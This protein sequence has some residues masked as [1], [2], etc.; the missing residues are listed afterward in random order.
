MD[1][2]MSQTIIRY[3]SEVDGIYFF[4]ERS[5]RWRRF[6]GRLDSLRLFF[7]TELRTRK[8][9]AVTS[10][11]KK[12][13]RIT[14]NDLHIST[15]HHKPVYLCASIFFAP[16]RPLSRSNDDDVS[17]LRISYGMRMLLAQVA[18]AVA[19]SFAVSVQVAQEVL[20][21]RFCI[22]FQLRHMPLS[23]SKPAS[24]N[25]SRDVSCL[26]L[27]NFQISFDRILAHEL[28]RIPNKVN[29]RYLDIVK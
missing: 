7:L 14:R 16:S 26:R 19:F 18:R 10:A 13:V 28:W 11:E 1:T 5:D 6:S 22:S 25:K 12:P 4:V 15:Y 3:S 2:A 23:I 29:T 8:V 9:G 21:S 17:L 20:S 27:F 24:R